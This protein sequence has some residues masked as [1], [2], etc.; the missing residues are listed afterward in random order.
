MAAVLA[1]SPAQSVDSDRVSCGRGSARPEFSSPQ[2]V[3]GASRRGVVGIR[4]SQI[5]RHI[6]GLPGIYSAVPLRTCGA[7]S[8]ADLSW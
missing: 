5:G 7:P 2:H 3:A 6:R 8:R 1:A 4:D